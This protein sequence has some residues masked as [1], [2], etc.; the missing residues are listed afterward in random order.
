MGTVR[1]ITIQ[2]SEDLLR[3]AQQ[4]T[5][6]G[7][8]ATVREGLRLVAAARAYEGLRRLRGKVAFSIDLNELRQDR[9]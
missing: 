2:I 3:K 7:V 8:T 4:C 6:K 5:G 9:R 1:K